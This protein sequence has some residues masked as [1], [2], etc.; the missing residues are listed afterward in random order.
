MRWQWAIKSIDSLLEDFQFK[1]EDKCVLMAELKTAFAKEFTLDKTLKVALDKKYRSQKESINALLST[2]LVDHNQHTWFA[3]FKNRSLS[4]KARAAVLLDRHHKLEI[5][6]L[7]KSYIHM[8][9]NR[10]FSSAQRKQEFVLYYFLHKHYHSQVK[11][12]QQKEKKE[13]TIDFSLV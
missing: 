13:S 4:N 9:M 5:Q 3:A 11:I 1:L 6:D 10:I 8:S 12:Q 2:R 7:L